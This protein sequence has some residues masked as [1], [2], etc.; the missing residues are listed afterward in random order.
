MIPGLK[1]K[2]VIKLW[3]GLRDIYFSCF[4]LVTRYYCWKRSIEKEDICIFCNWG[5]TLGGPKW[6]RKFAIFFIFTTHEWNQW[7]ILGVFLL[8]KIQFFLKNSMHIAQCVKNLKNTTAVMNMSQGWNQCYIDFIIV[9]S[10]CWIYSHFILGNLKK[11][12]KMLSFSLWTRQREWA[13][14]SNCTKKNLDL[15]YF[16][17]MLCLISKNMVYLSISTIW[18]HFRAICYISSAIQ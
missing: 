14:S 18:L 16:I 11:I 2:N 15:L 8:I 7:N 5:R 3:K 17:S 13:T 6:P 9:S 1:R 4:I 10:I 12:Q